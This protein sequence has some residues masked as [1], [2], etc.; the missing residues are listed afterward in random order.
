MDAFLFD[1]SQQVVPEG[2]E[3]QGLVVEFH[4]LAVGGFLD[5]SLD[6]DIIV[7]V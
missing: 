1:V 6:F 7:E 2:D 3:G 5:I 4:F